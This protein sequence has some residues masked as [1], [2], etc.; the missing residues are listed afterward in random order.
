[1]GINR[2]LLDPEVT[3]F[4]KGII[5]IPQRWVNKQLEMAA[6]DPWVD[7]AYDGYHC[8]GPKSFVEK[9]I[10][11]NAKKSG[12]NIAIPIAPRVSLQIIPVI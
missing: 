1:M 5:Y 6:K 12:T 2:L 11:L 4:Y 7:V 9:Q 10:Q 3:S 8:I